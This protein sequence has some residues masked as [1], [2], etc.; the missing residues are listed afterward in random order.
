MDVETITPQAIALTGFMGCDAR[1]ITDVRA[2]NLAANILDSRLVKRVREELGLVYG[3]Q[4][5]NGPGRVYEDSGV[6]F[7]GA[8]CA[9]DKPDEVI[10]EIETMYRALA[11]RGPTAEELDNA[12]KQIQNHLDTQL[13][14]PSFWFAQ[15]QTFD[16]HR[17]KLENLKNIPEAYAALT[18]EQVREVFGKYYVPARQVR[19]VAVPTKA[20][21]EEEAGAAASSTR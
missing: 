17:M 20:P 14:E 8:P 12:K 2:L 11:E 21:V 15:L 5:V 1:E 9:P 7:S 3:I 6:F 18:G 4:A 10:R 16:L 19:V 13:K